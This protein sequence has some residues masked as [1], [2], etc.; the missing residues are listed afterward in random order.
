MD[1][2]E[3]VELYWKRDELA[4]LETAKKYG[5]YC[6][7]IA[8][9]IL[10]KPEDSEECVSDTY[11]KAWNAIPDDRP[12]IF[13][14][15]LGKI[16]RNLAINIY[17]KSN[18]KKRGNGELDLILNELENCIPSNYDVEIE[19]ESRQICKAIN[20]F[21]L[22]LNEERRIIF[23]RRYWYGDSIKSISERFGFGESKIKSILFRCRNS[24][25]RYLKREDIIL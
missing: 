25:K 18:A 17:N 24:L 22:S 4:I 14:A 7:K 11:F 21:L 5:G 3:L 16:A 13:S 15:Y 8:Y 1:D 23:V 19:T 12:Y 10:Q 20:R 6:Y 2:C 9:N